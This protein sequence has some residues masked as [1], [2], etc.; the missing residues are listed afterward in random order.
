MFRFRGHFDRVEVRRNA[1]SQAMQDAVATQLRQAM[2]EFIRAVLQR[3]PVYTGMSRGS[4]RPMARVLRVAIPINPHPRAGYYKNKTPEAGERQSH[5][6]FDHTG[7]N[8]SVT[9]RVDVAHYLINEFYTGLRGQEN[10][11]HP[12]PWKSFEAGREA[13]HAYLRANLMRRLPNVASYITRTRVVI[14]G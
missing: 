7:L 3:V 11:I 1:L 4:L 10:L 14:G 2:R 9:F 12:T 6:E 8:Q 5:F 13:F